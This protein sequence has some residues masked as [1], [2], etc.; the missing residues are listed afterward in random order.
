MKYRSRI[1]I[2]ATILDTVSSG[3]AT[4]TK[5]MYE[6]YLSSPQ[7][8][9]YISFLLENELITYEEGTHIYR[10]T[11]QGRRFTHVY[12]KIAVLVTPKTN[13]SQI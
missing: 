8:K 13:S 7:L 10:I 4:K 1:E 12:N 2:I 9:E 11:E 5:I 3:T 6:A